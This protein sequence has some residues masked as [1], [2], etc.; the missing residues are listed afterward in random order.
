[1][2]IAGRATSDE[3]ASPSLTVRAVTDHWEAASTNKTTILRLLRSALYVLTKTDLAGALAYLVDLHAGGAAPQ[4][5][6]LARVIVEFL[7]A[8]ARVS[9]D[10]DLVPFLLQEP[11]P[12]SVDAWE[13]TLS[14]L[15]EVNVEYRIDLLPSAAKAGLT[16]LLDRALQD[17]DGVRAARDY[18]SWFVGRLRIGGLI[19]IVLD[20]FGHHLYEDNQRPLA[21]EATLSELEEIKMDVGA[22]RRNLLLHTLPPPD[23]DDLAQLRTQI[24]EAAKA[25]GAVVEPLSFAERLLPPS[26]G[27]DLSW[28]FN[29]VGRRYR[30]AY[31]ANW[32]EQLV[33]RRLLIPRAIAQSVLQDP[34]SELGEEW[35]GLSW[36]LAHAYARLFQPSQ[37]PATIRT[38]MFEANE[39]LATNDDLAEGLTFMGIEEKHH[40]EVIHTL[41]ELLRSGYELAMPLTQYPD[42]DDDV[43]P[44]LKRL[45]ALAAQPTETAILTSAVRTAHRNTSCDEILNLLS[46]VRGHMEA[47]EPARAL[48]VSARALSLYPWNDD[49]RTA[50]AFAY[51]DR[52][53]WTSAVEE[54]VI[55]VSLDPLDS[56]RWNQLGM[57]C[58][59]LGSEGDGRLAFTMAEVFKA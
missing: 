7:T 47:E 52:K 36:R 4:E 20:L 54:A 14:S 57:I 5:D 48:E 38:A 2:T 40:E 25:S 23:R 42:L 49:L 3:G 13:Q 32:G 30:E 9:S 8:R 6:S 11:I 12:E 33:R 10:Q 46:E 24:L 27:Q 37:H 17:T 50:R 43:Q 31:G 56:E 35:R 55:A 41:L 58:L 16:A 15:P 53:E 59:A 51:G 21:L 34:S 1:M 28:A 26:Y 22:S 19:S 18:D 45:E 39:L 29:S 44:K